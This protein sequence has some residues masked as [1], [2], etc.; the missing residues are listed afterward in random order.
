MSI[1]RHEVVIFGYVSNADRHR[2]L[3]D[4]W[5]T[6]VFFTKRQWSWLCSSYWKLEKK[7]QDLFFVK[8][9]TYCL[10]VAV[11]NHPLK[12]HEFRLESCY[13]WRA[14]SCRSSNRGVV[15]EITS[16]ELADCVF[17]SSLIIS[18]LTPC[19]ADIDESLEWWLCLFLN[20]VV[21]VVYWM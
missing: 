3:V 15:A 14:E 5:A 11:G 7:Q 12:K 9:W 16:C 2:P 20:I 19:V 13:S 10:A 6:N 4:S 8:C 1:S 17:K 18:S 21:T